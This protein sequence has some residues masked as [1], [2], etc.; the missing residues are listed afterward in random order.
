MLSKEEMKI[1]KQRYRTQHGECRYRKDKLGN[2]IEMRLTFNEWLNIWLTSGH[3]HERGCRKGQYVMSRYNDIGHYEIGNVEIKTAGDN[4][5]E[6]HSSTQWK[7]AVRLSTEKRFDNI[8]YQINQ[9]AGLKK[10][11]QDPVFKKK[12]REATQKACNKSVSCDG[13]IYESRKAAGMALAP[14]HL[15]DRSKPSWMQRQMKMYPTRYFYI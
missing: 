8:T 10:L 14:S 6:N 2:P 13:V 15:I 4:I 9:R 5:R 7:E 1:A 3:W 11:H 12:N